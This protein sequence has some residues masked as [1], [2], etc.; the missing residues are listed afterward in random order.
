MMKSGVSGEAETVRDINDQ[1]HSNK[2]THQTTKQ[3]KT[4]NEAKPK[5]DFDESD[6]DLW[7]VFKIIGQ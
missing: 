5:K 7:Y 2:L 3:I 6:P 4:P 1:D